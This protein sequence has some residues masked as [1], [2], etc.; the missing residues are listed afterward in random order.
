MARCK[1]PHAAVAADPLDPHLKH[2]C[3]STL[4][5]F[6]KMKKEAGDTYG[7]GA[8]MSMH[9]KEALIRFSLSAMWPN[10]KT[11]NTAGETD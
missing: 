3:P 9:T 7:N 6:N 2:L 8:D 11:N 1:Q 4:Q 10:P 5:E